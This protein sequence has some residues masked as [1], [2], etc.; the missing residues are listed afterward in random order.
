MDREKASIPD[1]QLD[2]LTECCICIFRWDNLIWRY[3]LNIEFESGLLKI[4][5]PECIGAKYSIYTI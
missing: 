5:T 2:F 4:N 1:H 3:T